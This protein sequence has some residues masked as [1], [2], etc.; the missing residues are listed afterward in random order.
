M[1]QYT[2]S[3]RYNDHQGRS[4]YFTETTDV[5]DRKFIEDFLRCR[6]PI[7]QFFINSVRQK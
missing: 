3:G 7:K 5:S 6:Y 4:H 2:V 1:T